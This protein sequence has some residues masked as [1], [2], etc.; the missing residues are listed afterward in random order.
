MNKSASNAV[1]IL[2]VG[3]GGQVGRRV[4]ELLRLSGHTVLA[5]TGWDLTVAGSAKGLAEDCDVLMSCAGASVSMRA[6]DKR[7]FSSVDPVI[8]KQLL[9]ETLRAGAYRFVYLSVH[10]EEG[11]AHTA[12][13]RAHESFVEEL[14]QT[15][16]SSTVVRPTGI[17]SAFEDLLPM[18]RKGFLPLIGNGLARTNPIDPQDV[19]ELMVRY[20]AAGPLDLPCGGPDIPT[21]RQINQ[22]IGEA[23]GKPNA[24]MPNA[25]PGLVRM[26]GRLVR[27]FHSRIAE[28]MEFY[29]AVATQDC[30]AP[31]LGMR[32]MSEYF[33][34]V[35]ARL[36]FQAT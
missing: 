8:H 15:S 25:P 29:S 19:A 24:W 12:Y 28:L 36:A 7:G 6:K 26:E 13:V 4:N 22:I 2:L 3:A 16:L 10:V 18:A 17:F 20:V 5:V 11:Y 23:A 34:V 14:R 35:P 21:R 27:P 1:R 33:G 30:I 31:Q 32:R 9:K